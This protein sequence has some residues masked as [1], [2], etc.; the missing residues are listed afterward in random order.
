M[1]A[2]PRCRETKVTSHGPQPLVRDI[3]P[4]AARRV[5]SLGP[6]R[7]AVLAVQGL[8][9]AP[10]ATPAQSALAVA[11]LAVQG[12]ADAETLGGPSPPRGEPVDHVARG[13]SGPRT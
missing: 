4:G 7:D 2:A 8:T 6:L 13:R 5:A 11:S 9:Q 12:F 10:A 3:A 1:N